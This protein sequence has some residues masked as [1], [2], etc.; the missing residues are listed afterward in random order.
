MPCGSSVYGDMWVGV[1]M[2]ADTVLLCNDWPVD[3]DDDDKKHGGRGRRG[4][5]MKD[6]RGEFPK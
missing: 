1:A 2:A 3:D 6:K 5:R 4:E